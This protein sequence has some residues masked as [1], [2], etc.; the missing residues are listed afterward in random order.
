MSQKIAY[1]AACSLLS[2]ALILASPAAVAGQYLSAQLALAD[3]SNHSMLGSGLSFV[4]T[5]GVEMPKTNEYLAF[6][7][8]FTKSISDPDYH[9]PTYHAEFDYYT[10]A[11]YGVMTF[12]TTEKFSL[13]ARAGLLYENW[14][15]RENQKVKK[16]DTDIEPS[17]GGGGIYRLSP[18]T[19]LIAEITIIEGDIIHLSAGAQLRF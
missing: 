4:G 17:I 1:P 11:G 16:S 10:L 3:V 19:N 13:R 14:E 9:T 12:P 15:Y 2:A 5:Y 6:E 7:A 8:E 18:R